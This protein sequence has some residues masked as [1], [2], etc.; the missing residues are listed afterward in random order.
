MGQQI[1][2]FE[3][4]KSDFSFSNVDA[5]A[6]QGADYADFALNRSNESAWITSGSVDADNTTWEVEMTDQ[7]D[8]SEIILIKHNFK[9]FTIK[10]WN[11]SAYVDFSPAINVTNNTAETNHYSVTQVATNNIRITI[12]GTQVVNSD[13]YLFQFICSNLIG[14][15]NAWP[16]I[17]PVLSRNRKKNKMLSGKTSIRESIGAVKIDLSI[18]ILSNNADLGI[19]E[20]LY[21]SNDGFLVWL[22]GGSEA[23]FANER[24]G[25]RLEDIYLVKCS[26]EWQPEY[27]EGIYTNGMK[28]QIALEEVVD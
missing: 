13:K 22:C 5:T 9:N 11:G 3:K 6:S 19:I 21:Y 1:M 2:F 17:K 8:V 20:D 7:K 16:I 15:L 28:I 12:T 26:D 24:K 25:Y 10:Y 23:Q 4:S 14:Q 27:A 18:K